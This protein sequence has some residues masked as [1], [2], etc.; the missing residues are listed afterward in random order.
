MYYVPP[1]YKEELILSIVIDSVCIQIII[2]FLYIGGK[3]N[4]TWFSAV[5]NTI[6][7]HT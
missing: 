5:I 3:G 7:C 4:S 6:L 1:V 2:I